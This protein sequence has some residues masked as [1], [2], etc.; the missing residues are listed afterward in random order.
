MRWLW[1]FTILVGCGPIANSEM[2]FWLDNYLADCQFFDECKSRPTY[3]LNAIYKVESLGTT[4]DPARIG[5]CT[6][7]PLFRVIRVTAMDNQCEDRALI[8]HEL[9]HCIHN[10]RHSAD[11]PIM[12]PELSHSI[13]WCK[14]WDAVLREFMTVQMKD[15][16]RE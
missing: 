7:S 4:D 2:Q 1:L 16:N 5:S 6:I 9:G 13:D 15:N 3:K 8:Y 11:S 14:E 10:L 12:A